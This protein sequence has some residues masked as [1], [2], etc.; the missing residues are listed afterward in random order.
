VAFDQGLPVPLELADSEVVKLNDQHAFV[1]LGGA[2]RPRALV[3]AWLRFG[4]SHP[5]TVF[6]KWRLIPVLDADDRVVELIR[7]FF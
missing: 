5:C 7:T 2:D 3:G 4:I 6:D 1:R